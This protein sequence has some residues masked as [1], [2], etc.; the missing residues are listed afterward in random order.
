MKITDQDIFNLIKTLSRTEKGNYVK[1]AKSQ[2]GKAG[3]KYMQLFKALDDMDTL[4]TQ[5]LDKK[6]ARLKF[7]SHRYRIRNYLYHS[8]VNF[9]HS[10]NSSASATEHILQQLSKAYVLQKRK[11]HAASNAFA[12][13]AQTL[14]DHN[15]LYSLS[16]EAVRIK[17]GNH[18]MLYREEGSTYERT[19]QTHMHGYATS[20]FQLLSIT[21][22]SNLLLME[23]RKTGAAQTKRQQKIYE[24]LYSKYIK[25]EFD[26]D[27]LDV[28]TC[29]HYY[30][31]KSVLGLCLNRPESVAKNLQKAYDLIWNNLTEFES[32]LPLINIGY[33]LIDCR[34]HNEEFAI[35][36]AELNKLNTWL[37]EN[38][39]HMPPNAIEQFLRN[40]HLLK[41]NL[42]VIAPP[43][44]SSQGQL[45]LIENFFRGKS[46]T[47]MQEFNVELNWVCHYIYTGDFKAALRHINAV[48]GNNQLNSFDVSL[49]VEIEL[50]NLL[51]HTEIGNLELVRSLVKS[52]KRKFKS[53]HTKPFNALTNLLL[54][55]FSI[56]SA[57]AWKGKDKAW[58][59][60][61]K[62]NLLQIYVKQRNSVFWLT[63]NF[64]RYFAQFKTASNCTPINRS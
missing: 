5:I 40:I 56:L 10:N 21:R 7:P 19:F 37:K 15:G 64:Y 31:G 61:F 63:F 41:F 26:E 43:Q 47:H 55:Y 39:K 57:D 34:I 17:H 35:A 3:I 2:P 53:T 4:N 12:D 60:S 58:R 27:S 30:D 62:Q 20:Q 6:L 29:Y 59:D 36:R 46:L 14:A 13:S 45:P 25:S 52:F 24:T 51:V 44:E 1:Y 9:L 38:S 50:L 32:K 11:L 42:L 28:W 16:S 49:L 22:A 48:L 8:I 54:D 23:Y 18:L 33:A